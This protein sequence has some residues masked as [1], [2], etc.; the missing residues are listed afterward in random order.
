VLAAELDGPLNDIMNNDI[1][2][3]EKNGKHLLSLIN[4]RA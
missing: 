3:I 2:L 1:R 4:R